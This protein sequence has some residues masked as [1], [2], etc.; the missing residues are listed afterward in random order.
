MTPEHTC[1]CGRSFANA[2]DLRVHI[3][4]AT[5]R[6]PIHRCSPEHH[7]PHSLGDTRAL[8]WLAL[9]ERTHNAQ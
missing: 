3:A 4:E 6:W 7:D 2:K 1:S 8:R 5:D 9:V